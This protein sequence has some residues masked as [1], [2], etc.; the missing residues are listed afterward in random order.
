MVESNFGTQ[1]FGL[2]D[3][4][5]AVSGNTATFAGLK[6]GIE[7]KETIEQIL[8]AKEAKKG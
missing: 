2:S 1:H 3:E 7:N 5:E 4:K 8:N 6:F